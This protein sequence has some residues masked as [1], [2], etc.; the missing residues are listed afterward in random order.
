MKLFLKTLK[1]VL[2]SVTSIALIA[3]LYIYFIY[4]GRPGEVTT[5]DQAQDREW[6]TISFKGKTLCSDGSEF[7]IFVKK[8]NSDNL[9]IHF[10]GGGAC[11]DDPTCAKPISLMNIFD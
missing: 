8:G 4:F 6:H 9:I 7:A 1:W 10:S 5:I 3:F 2:I 11:W